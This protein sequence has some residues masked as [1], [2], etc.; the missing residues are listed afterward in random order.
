MYH[1]GLKCN[2]HFCNSIFIKMKREQI[3]C[4]AFKL[5]ALYG[6]KRVSMDDIVKAL[7]ISKKTL[8]EFFPNKEELVYECAKYKIER[9]FERLSKMYDSLPD[10][11][12]LMVYKGVDSFK[13]YNAISPAFYN[14][15]R[16]YPKLDEFLKSWRLSQDKIGKQKISQGIE[17]GYFLPHANYDIFTQ[18]FMSQVIDK[19][20]EWSDKYT[21]TQICFIS[22]ITLFRGISTEKGRKI[23]EEIEKEGL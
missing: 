10:N 9:E 21:P 7:R 19:Q 17:D 6:I 2:T 11:I 1:L 12:R 23:L 18:M 3:L 22:L 16:Y 14:D 13:F 8:Y 20:N 4:T 5:Y 15:V